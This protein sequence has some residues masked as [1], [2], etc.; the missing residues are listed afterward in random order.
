MKKD[1]NYLLNKVNTNKESD[2]VKFMFSELEGNFGETFSHVDVAMCAEKLG[3]KQSTVKGVLGSLV[4][5]DILFT[6]DNENGEYV[7]SFVEQDY[8]E[9]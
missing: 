8:L 5:K 4:N 6:W 3:W 1:L 9:S 2:L 7:I